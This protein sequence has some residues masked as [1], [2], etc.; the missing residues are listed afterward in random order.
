MRLLIVIL[1]YRS[2]SL[3]IDCLRSLAPE[4]AANDGTKVVVTDAPSGDD[5]V[6]RIGAA[7]GEQGWA[8]WCTLTPLAKNGGF[9]Y[10]NNEAIKP[11]LASVDK[12]DYV[13]L[14]NPDTVVRP[15][16]VDALLA[17]MDANPK[18]GIAGSRLEHPDGAPQRSAFRFPSVLSEVESGMRLGPVSKALKR[19]IVAPPV[20]QGAE[21]VRTDWVAGASMIVRREVFEAIGLLDD[22]YFMYFEE[23]DFCLRAARAGGHAGTCRPAE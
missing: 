16:A 23:V 2:A 12:P 8:D 15:G 22:G 11:A 13:L 21:P 9:A 14:L 17:F 6:A 3:C 19:R 20:P 18:A 5:S 10:G 4:V 1:N 7:I